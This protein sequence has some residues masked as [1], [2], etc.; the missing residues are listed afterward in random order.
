VSA[1]SRICE[2]I[3]ERADELVELACELISFDT[4][5]RGEPDEPARD[6]QAL[7]ELLAERLRAAGFEVELW[8]PETGFLDESQR[9][10]PAGLG[11]AGRPQ[12]IARW[13]G[14]DGPSLLFNGHID[15]VSGEPRERWTSDPFA[16][17][18]RD[19]VLYGR[20]A[21]DMKGG[22]ATMIVAAEALAQSGVDGVGEL[23]VNTVTDEEWNGAGALAVATRGIGAD[24]G[25]VTEASGFEAWVGC[26]GVLN[27]TVSVRGR[28][29]HSE[30]PQPDW[31]EGGAVNAIEKAVIVLDAVRELRERW[32]V[33]HD[34]PL[35]APGELIPTVIEGGEWWVSYPASCTTVIDVTYLPEQGDAD[36][37]WGSGLEREIEEW[38][39]SR[40][41]EDPWLA[42]HPPS[43]TWGTN[44][45]PAEIDPDHPIVAAVLAGGATV[46]RPGRAAAFQGWHDAATFTR[47]GTPTIS[48]GPT[49]LSTD[50][51]AIAHAVDEHVPVADLVPCAQALAVGA[52]WFWDAEA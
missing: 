24:A 9:Q 34:H 11:F 3:E 25:I 49:G 20:G 23:V 35:L 14:G 6:E 38:I 17:E 33:D 39:L 41:R 28:P 29:G 51:E 27:P 15:V 4:T 2:A 31:R 52:L 36:G 46:G 42:E 45:P 40:A 21:C 5:T 1:A 48:Y 26:R 32:S 22:V 8:E 37:G 44:L 50:G 16:P 7:Q 10:V 13:R 43:V 47:C 19:G 18:I 12:L 30:L